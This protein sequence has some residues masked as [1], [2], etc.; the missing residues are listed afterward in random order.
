MSKLR[1]GIGLLLLLTALIS[2]PAWAS[3]GDE[4]QAEAAARAFAALLDA[5]TPGD[6]WTQLSTLAQVI[7]HREQWQRQHHALRTA[8]GAV[9]KR[10]LRG[11]TLQ[12]RYPMVPDGRYAIVQF[13]VSFAHKQAGV[14][15]IVLV[16]S[17]DGRWLI[18]DY[19]IS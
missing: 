15:T 18:H 1:P 10:T 5:G 6:A 12:Q 2:G 13:D 8:Y 11:V 19:I 14:E 9:Q 16:V 3:E 7:K 17:P 4:R